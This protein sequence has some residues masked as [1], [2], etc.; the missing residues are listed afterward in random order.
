LGDDKSMT[1]Q[2]WMPATDLATYLHDL[3][4]S[5]NSGDVY[6]VSRAREAITAP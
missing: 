1:F 4:H 5:A 3:P 6:C 2:R